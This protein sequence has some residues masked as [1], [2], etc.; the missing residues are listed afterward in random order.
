MRRAGV[1]GGRIGRTP[2]ATTNAIA[3]ISRIA[4]TLASACADSPENAQGSSVLPWLVDGS[5]SGIAW[6]AMM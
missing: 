2:I 5:C 6:P 3:A 1:D 4:S